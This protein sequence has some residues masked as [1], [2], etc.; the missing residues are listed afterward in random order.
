MDKSLV[1]VRRAY[2]RKWAREHPDNVKR[3]QEKFWKKL[4]AAQ[5]PGRQ[6]NQDP[7]FNDSDNI[8]P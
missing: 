2:Y 5:D 8:E 7:P 3:S 4:L 6:N 1:E